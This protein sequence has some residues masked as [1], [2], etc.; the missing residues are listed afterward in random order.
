LLGVQIVVL[1]ALALAYLSRISLLHRLSRGELV[2]RAQ[3]DAADSR[4]VGLGRL[5]LLVFIATVVVWLVW[6]Y[7][8]QA[9]ARQLTIKKLMFSPGWAVGWWFIPIANLFQPFRAV[10]EL[11]QASGSTDLS[12]EGTW[13]VLVLWWA[14]WLGF[15]LFAQFARSSSP[16]NVSDFIRADELQLI[17]V[18][19]GI[20]SAALAIAIVRAVERRQQSRIQALAKAPPLQIP[21]PPPPPTGPVPE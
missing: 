20:A 13:P 8:A 11:W 4:L 17:S 3:V 1:V 12:E 21:L 7:R 6:Q 14:G 9:N 10:R 16:N 15:N 5:W 19:L 18:P 2:T